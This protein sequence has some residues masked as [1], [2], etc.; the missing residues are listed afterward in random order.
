MRRSPKDLH[1]ETYELSP[2]AHTALDYAM[3][4]ANPQHTVTKSRLG[5]LMSSL[6]TLAA[7][8][9]PDET[10][11]IARLE[12]QRDSIQRQIDQIQDHGVTVIANAEAVEKAREIL[13]LISDLPADFARVQAEVEKVNLELR[14]S[15]VED[16]RTA[17]DVLDNVFR[18]VDM[19]G[20]SEAGKAFGGFYDLFLDPEL[21]HRFDATL[22]SVMSRDFVD[23]LEPDERLQLQLLMNTLDASSAQVH[24]S[25][26]SLSRSLR[27]FVQSREAESQQALTKA[28]NEATA[29][30]LKVA[31]S[32]IN[33]GH[34]V[35]LELELSTHQAKS[36]SSW[37]LW[38]PQ[39]YRIEEGVEVAEAGE[40]D[41]EEL[42]RHIRES[43]IDWQELTGAVNASV[44][45]RG[46]AT[47][48]DVLQDHPAT[49]GVASVVGVITLVEKHG[50]RS[51]G[52]EYLQWDSRS[53]QH[54]QAR[55]P[56]HVFD[57]AIEGHHYE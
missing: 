37:T 22:E 39:D 11:A 20:Q 26:T 32:G 44:Q 29:E 48:G 46:V 1:D 35:C 50:R 34:Q 41:L 23:K 36:V 16:D 2:D 57:H 40:V 43:E 30:A 7:E 12:A 38:D 10:T 51:E 31:R 42:R 15:I 53:G 24:D 56:V 17:A 9:D 4:L 19:I 52:T 45:R 3:Q 5:T 33:P 55:Y 54:W 21:S 13:N 28:I 49:Q 8:T 14:Q 47:I 18:G 25:M 27:R 6:H